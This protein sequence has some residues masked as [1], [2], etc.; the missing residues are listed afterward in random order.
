MRDAAAS[1]AARAADGGPTPPAEDRGAA[2][3][4]R[5]AAD[6]V[7]LHAA[8]VRAGLQ[9]AVRRRARPRVTR[10]SDH[11]PAT[12]TSCPRRRRSATDVVAEALLDRD[13]AAREA[14]RIEGRDQVVGVEARARRSPPA[15]SGRGR[16]GG[17]R[18]AA[19]T[20]PAGRRRACPR[21]GTA[22]RRGGRAPGRASCAGARPAAS[23]DGRPSSSQNICARVPS[24]QPSAGITGELCSQPPLG[25]AE[26]ML[27]QRSTTSR[28]TV[29]PRVGSPAPGVDR[30]ARRRCGRRPDARAGSSARR[31]LAD[32][33]APLV[34]VRLREQRLERHLAV[35]V[36]RL[37]VG[38]GE[39]RALG[40]DVDELGRRELG[41]VEA[42][43]QRELLQAHRPGRPRQRLADGQPA[44]L[45]RGDRLERRPPARHVVAGE[46][47]ALGGD[48]AVDLLGDEALVVRARA[49]ARSP[50]RASRRAT[51]RGCAGRS[52]RAPGCG[53]ARRPRAP[54][55]R[56]RPSRAT[57]R[58]SSSVRSIVARIPATSGK[59][60][61]A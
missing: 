42:V 1:V 50:P 28:W 39:L 19:P 53:R 27:P 41:E 14:A 37:A 35:A 2:G 18:R 29:S 7:A 57:P 12:S 40:D 9:Q 60:C 5:S 51:R 23:E 49:P 26:T 3:R 15:G 61:S 33:R 54:A 46:Q 17:G 45:E 30:G 31:V 52:R 36:E 38:E 48:E 59:P 11:G 55:G 44:V 10:P 32:E 43:E 16:R 13:R 21:R 4:R 24:G 58:S 25:V 8:R 6:G 20:A 47:A 34:V 56:A 22:R